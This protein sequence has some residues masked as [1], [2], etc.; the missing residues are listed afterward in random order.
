MRAPRLV[1]AILCSCAA[2]RAAQPDAIEMEVA[3]VVPAHDGGAAVLLTDAK[4]SRVLP[5]FVGG[6]EAVSIHL[7][8]RKRHF[9]RPLTHDLLDSIL[10]ELGGK[11][12]RA[13]I[14]EVRGE[15]MI[16]SLVVQ[17]AGGRITRLDARPSDAIALALGSGLPVF[18][19]RAV[20][21]TA[22]VS[23]DAPELEE[24]PQPGQPGPI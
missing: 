16:G 23:A 22:G 3:A 8:L 12:V 2:A 10:H 5:I 14:D 24:K 19:A 18:V 7:R 11:V 20:L 21:E 4:H 15:T 6:T 17:S 13:Q 9:D 1:F